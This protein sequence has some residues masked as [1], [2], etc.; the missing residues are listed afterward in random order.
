MQK[1]IS[2]ILIFIYL[3]NFLF[4]TSYATPWLMKGKINSSISVFFP[5]HQITLIFLEL[6]TITSI[7]LLIISLINSIIC[8]IKRIPPNKIYGHFISISWL[9]FA[10]NVASAFLASFAQYATTSDPIVSGQCIIGAIYYPLRPV[11]FLLF[12][13]IC[14]KV[15]KLF[16][17]NKP[18]SNQAIKQM[19]ESTNVE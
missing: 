9:V 16:L 12:L 1:V 19:G 5:I 18:A 14:I 10:F 13:H 15:I 4:A 3:Q 11:S 8:V 6:L 17:P 7:V 2:S